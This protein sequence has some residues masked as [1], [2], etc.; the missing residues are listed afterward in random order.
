MNVLPGSAY[1][2]APEELSRPELPDPGGRAVDLEPVASLG[3]GASEAHDVVAD[4]AEFLG[5]HLEACPGPLH[6]LEIARD[7]LWPR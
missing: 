7:P 5:D 2:T 1:D 3:A 4:L 6:V